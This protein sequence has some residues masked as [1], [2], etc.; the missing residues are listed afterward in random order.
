VF[1]RFRYGLDEFIAIYK[2]EF[3]EE[4]SR[5]DVSEMASRLL[6]PPTSLARIR[7]YRLKARAGFRLD[8]PQSSPDARF[9]ALHQDRRSLRPPRHDPHHA[10]PPRCGSL[11]RASGK[12][13]NLLFTVSR[14]TELADNHSRSVS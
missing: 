1:N 7:G 8:Q 3:G 9:R 6:C 4:N 5:N 10:Q 14:E 13:P 12:C 2:K 11:R